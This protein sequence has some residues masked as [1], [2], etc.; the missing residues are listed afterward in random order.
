VRGQPARG[1]CIAGVIAVATLLSA[2]NGSISKRELVV[3]FDPTASPE[4]H[5]AARD[6]CAGAAPR[7]SPEPIVHNDKYPT[8]RISDVRFRIDHANDKDIAQLESCLARQPGVV[9]FEDT[10]AL[11]S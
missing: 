8:T 11:T 4:D 5:R 2:C 1:A 3:H 9:G 10:A 7:T 6:A